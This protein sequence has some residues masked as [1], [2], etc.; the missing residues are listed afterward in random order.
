MGEDGLIAFLSG[1]RELTFGTWAW[2]GVK[3]LVYT[4]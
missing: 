2:Q 1:W 3:E 4:P